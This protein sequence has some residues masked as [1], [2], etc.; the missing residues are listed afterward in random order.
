MLER[1]AESPLSDQSRAQHRNLL[2][3]GA[4][5]ILIAQ[6]SLVP[7]RISALGVD[8]EASDRHGIRIALMVAIAYFLVTFVASAIADAAAWRERHVEARARELSN[9]ANIAKFNEYIDEILPQLQSDPG[10]TTQTWERFAEFQDQL[11]D[12]QRRKT[13]YRLLV[14]VDLMRAFID[15]VV[16]VGAGLAAIICLAWGL[17]SDTTPA[18]QRFLLG[19]VRL[20][21]P[22]VIQRASPRS[23]SPP[24]SEQ[25]LVSALCARSR[26]SRPLRSA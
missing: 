14:P 13:L 4:V 15:F 18:K 1:L 22:S 10:R 9:L 16:P 23:V 8:L 25:S 12:G 26:Q 19:H 24:A 7:T 21:H 5:G 11:L 17:G 2:L 20:F 6:L 3:A